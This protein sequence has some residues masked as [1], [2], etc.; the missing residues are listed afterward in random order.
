MKMRVE[1]K[2]K[3]RKTPDV[4]TEYLREH[5]AVKELL[6]QYE[7]AQDILQKNEEAQTSYDSLHPFYV[8]SSNV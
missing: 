1:A 3:D 8:Y 2:L 5:P 4:L 7:A 6:K